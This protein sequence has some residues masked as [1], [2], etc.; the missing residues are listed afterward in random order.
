[1]NATR[2]FGV[3]RRRGR[4]ILQSGNQ[5]IALRDDFVPTTI[6]FLALAKLAGGLVRRKKYTAYGPPKTVVD[7]FDEQFIVEMLEIPE[8]EY[9]NFVDF[10]NENNETKLVLQSK[11]ELKIL[12]F[13]I[14]QKE[15]FI[16]K[17]T[18]G[19]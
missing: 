12:E 2:G 9:Y 11:D 14:V 3:Y 17:Y 13:L 7:Y 19:K 18:I 16:E 1:M 6:D 4:A 10:V 15:V 8:T 5:A